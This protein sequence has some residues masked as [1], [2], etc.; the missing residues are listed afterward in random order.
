MEQAEEH[1]GWEFGDLFPFCIVFRMNDVGVC[2]ATGETRLKIVKRGCRI[3]FG[4]LDFNRDN[5]KA[6]P[7]FV[8]KEKV[9]LNIIA[10]LFHA[11]VGI[12]IQLLSLGGNHL[13][14]HVF[15]D[16]T[17]VQR[18][19]SAHDGFV[20]LLIGYLIFTESQTDQKTGIAHVA[21]HSSIIFAQSKTDVGIVALI[22]E[23]AYHGII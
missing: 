12:E 22:A 7:V 16:H 14:N 5:S 18:Q 2:D 1:V 9:N 4:G 11:V 17:L 6:G 13:G 20:Q 8:G 21:F 10:V 23:I 19:P 15:I 3:V